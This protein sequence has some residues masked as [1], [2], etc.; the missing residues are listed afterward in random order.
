MCG[1]VYDDNIVMDQKCKLDKCSNQCG[2]SACFH[3]LEDIICEAEDE[4]EDEDGIS[5]GECLGC[6]EIFQR[7]HIIKA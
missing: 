7:I 4:D 6:G 2:F 3:C 1:I 5:V